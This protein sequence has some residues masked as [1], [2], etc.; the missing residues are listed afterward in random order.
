M[1]YYNS[2]KFYFLLLKGTPVQVAATSPTGM[3]YN[4]NSIL[5][6][7]VTPPEGTPLASV[8]LLKTSRL[9]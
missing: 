4:E 7:T 2:Y 5:S 1:G 6:F 8:K 3:T 9:D